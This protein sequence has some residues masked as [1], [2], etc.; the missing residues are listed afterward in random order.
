MRAQDA[1]LNGPDAGLWGVTQAHFRPQ[2]DP[3]YLQG[4]Q[5]YF[6]EK[7]IHNFIFW[8]YNANGSAHQSSTLSLAACVCRDN[9]ISLLNDVSTS[10][11]L[12]DTPQ[13]LWSNHCAETCLA[14]LHI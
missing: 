9:A 6:R 5:L 8:A 7:R 4:L 2:W 13:S 14:Y 12:M 1:P 3:Q 11:G 10:G